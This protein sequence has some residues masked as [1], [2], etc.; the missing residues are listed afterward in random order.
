MNLELRFCRILGSRLFNIFLTKLVLVF[1]KRF[2]RLSSS[3]SSCNDFTNLD[4][5][6]LGYDY[7]Y[8]R[9]TLHSIDQSSEDRV[10]DWIAKNLHKGG[11]FFL[12]ARSTKDEIFGEGKRVGS[13]EYFTD[14]YRR[15]LNLSEIHEKIN[16][17]GFEILYSKE[18]KGLAPYKKEDPVIIRLVAK[19]V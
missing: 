13:N 4:N 14:H 10:I 3:S 18:G 7:I 1:L 19:K 17:I 6:N 5:S 11:Y 2:F 9:F 8:S 12:E 16:S 15:F